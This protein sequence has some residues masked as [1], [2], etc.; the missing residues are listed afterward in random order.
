MGFVTWSLLY[1]EAC[2]TGSSENSSGHSKALAGWE[3]EEASICEVS[4]VGCGHPVVTSLMWL[5]VLIS[6]D[7]GTSRTHFTFFYLCVCV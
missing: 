5:T 2:K 3:E 4:M 6:W 1:P 7:W